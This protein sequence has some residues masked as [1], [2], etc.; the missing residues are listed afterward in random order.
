[1]YSHSNNSFSLLEE[2]ESSD[3]ENTYEHECSHINEHNRFFFENIKRSKAFFCLKNKRNISKK[4]FKTKMCMYV[5]ISTDENNNIKY[6]NNCNRPNCHFAHTK[7]ELNCA[8]CVFGETCKF[9]DSKTRPC[10]FLHPSETLSCFKK[11][12]GLDLPGKQFY[13]Q[14]LVLS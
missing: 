5:N 1:M 11:R 13:I 9:K 4:L 3:D 12:T 10:T 14:P 6:I 7:D 8:E 2:E